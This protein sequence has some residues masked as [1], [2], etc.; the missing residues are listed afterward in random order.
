[1][2]ARAL[3]T[4]CLVLVLA[5][6]GC[7]GDGPP[8][9]GGRAGEGGDLAGL[10]ARAGQLAPGAGWRSAGRS[11]PP[12]LRPDPGIQAV[13][14]LRAVAGGQPLGQ[15]WLLRYAR[16]AAAAAG[17]REVAEGLRAMAG[18]LPETWRPGVGQDTAAAQLQLAA[19][20][21]GPRPTLAIAFRRCRDLAAIWL[22]E[23]VPGSRD[24]LTGYAGRLDA[25]LAAAGGCG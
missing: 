18:G 19:S 13:A 8:D 4:G 2:R 9:R 6:S 14:T 16:P 15:V 17:A 23:P 10:I 20:S 22:Q 1:M 24:Q 7:A 25:G 11:L 3:W 21:A 12:L 5:L